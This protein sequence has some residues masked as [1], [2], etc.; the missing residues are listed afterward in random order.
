MQQIVPALGHRQPFFGEE[1]AVISKTQST[2]INA[3]GFAAR[4]L[5]RR[6]G[7]VVQLTQFRGVV[8]LC[9]TFLCR[10]QMRV[11]S[12]APPDIS[13]G[14]GLLCP[15]L[16]QGFP[17]TCPG[18]AY[19]YACTLLKLFFHKLTPR[20]IRTAIVSKSSSGVQR[21]CNHQ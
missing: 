7:P 15:N 3:H 9:Q 2:Q 19:F 21:Q 14:I 11:T 5:V 12:A 10:L 17:G 4:G 1:F 20:Y 16:S 13:L 6:L 8:C 18:H